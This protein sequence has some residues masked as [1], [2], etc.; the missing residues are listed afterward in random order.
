MCLI[1]VPAKN[2]KAAEKIHAAYFVAG[3]GLEP[4]SVV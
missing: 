1:Y 4:T 2:K 3:A